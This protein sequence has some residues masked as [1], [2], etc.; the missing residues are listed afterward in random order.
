MHPRNG[1]LITGPI[2]CLGIAMLALVAGPVH[3]QDQ[4]STVLGNRTELTGVNETVT[5]G[6]TARRLV[7]SDMIEGVGRDKKL[8]VGRDSATAVK[9]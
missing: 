5:V 4:S 1:D 9:R 3:A 7:G 6:V 2:C 8:F